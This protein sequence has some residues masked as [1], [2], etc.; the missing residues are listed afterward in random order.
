MLLLFVLVPTCD[1]I[2][3]FLSVDFTPAVF[4]LD[5]ALPE[6]ASTTP[7]KS[8]IGGADREGDVVM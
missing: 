8:G 7:S 1:V 4:Y 6:T 3:F 5:G 2:E